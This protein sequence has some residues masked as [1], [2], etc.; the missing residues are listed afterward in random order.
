VKFKT[1]ILMDSLRMPFDEA[2]KFCSE[3]GCDGV[4]FYAV[5]HHMSSFSLDL[6]TAVF[7]KQKVASYGL[8]IPAL[9]GDLGGF[10]FEKAEDN[11]EKIRKTK[12][13]VDFAE[14]LGTRIITSHIGVISSENSIRNTNMKEALQEIC[15]YAEPRGIS[16]AV[17]TGPEKSSVLRSFIE[18][19]GSSALK[20]NFDPANLAMVQGEKPSEAVRILSDLIIHT[21]V[22]DGIRLGP[23]RPLEVYHSFADGNT[24]KLDIE[25]FFTEE[26]LGC[27][28]VDFGDYLDALDSVGY[29]EYLTIEREAGDNRQNDISEGLQF[30]KG[31]ISEK[32]K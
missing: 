20:I 3:S 2:L 17:E 9:C 1:G 21:H 12:E 13:V 10:G 5:P 23:C 4:Q 19:T 26:P 24:A 29:S 28:Q 16:I 31:V 18:E 15:A 14:K 27:G 6:N 25:S 7:L 22:K 32:S 8:E 11:P 30:L